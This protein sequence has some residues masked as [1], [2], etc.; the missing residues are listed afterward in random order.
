MSELHLYEGT[1][2]E[3]ARDG[4]LAKITRDRVRGIEA[5]APEVVRMTWLRRATAFLLLRKS[6]L[7]A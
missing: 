3:S 6:Y 2:F 5:P 1:E 7:R 4:E